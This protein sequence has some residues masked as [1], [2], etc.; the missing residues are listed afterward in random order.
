M[1]D[2]RPKRPASSSSQGSISD[3]PT[4]PT[5]RD[6]HPPEKYRRKTVYVRA[7]LDRSQLRLLLTFSIVGGRRYPTSS[8]AVSQRK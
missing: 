7:Y 2:D 6:E 3:F 8:T 5:D 4:D 1:P